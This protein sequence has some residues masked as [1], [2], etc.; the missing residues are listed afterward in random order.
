MARFAVC[1]EPVVVVGERSD[2]PCD[3]GSTHSSQTLGSGK[4][5]GT[6]CEPQVDSVLCSL[7]AQHRD[8]RH[9]R[10]SPPSCGPRVKPFLHLENNSLE[11][12]RGGNPSSHCN[13]H[14]GSQREIRSVVS[15]RSECRQIADRTS[16]KTPQCVCPCASPRVPATPERTS[17]CHNVHESGGGYNLGMDD[18]GWWMMVDDDG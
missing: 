16:H 2:K 4:R 6:S 7:H 3:H 8:H 18:D 14:G 1:F 12:K 9:S 11:R 5:W 13:P 17:Q 10:S 15:Q